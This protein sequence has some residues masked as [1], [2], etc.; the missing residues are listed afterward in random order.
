M[1]SKY[2][3]KNSISMDISYN[4]APSDFKCKTKQLGKEKEVRLQK[5]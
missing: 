5:Q 2:P 4:S 3:A 1:K